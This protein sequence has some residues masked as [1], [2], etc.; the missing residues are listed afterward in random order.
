M[1][2]VLAQ[3]LMASVLVLLAVSLATF[4]LLDLSPGDAAQALVGESASADQIEVLRRELGLDLSMLERYRRF[5]TAAVLRGDLGNSLT[6]G[7]PIAP[8]LAERFR[9]TLVLALAA[10][11]LALAIG[12]P[13]AVVA[14]ARP[15]GIGDSLGMVGA[16]LGLSM[17]TFWLAL[18][19]MLT[20][21]LRLKWLPVKGAGSPAHLILPAVSLALPLA[22]VIARLLRSSLLEVRQ[23]DHVRTAR[24]KGLTRGRLWQDHLLRNSIVPTVTVV[25]LHLGH[26]L[27]GTFVVETIFA[28]P[29]LGSLIVRAVFER[30]YPT[31]TA[32]ALLIAVVYQ[33]LNLAVDL[34]QAWLDP[35]TRQRAAAG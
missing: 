35:R 29:G 32:A 30:D 22:A 5:V 23:A 31:V 27:G 8:L 33:F 34:L 2:R 26:L 15:G 7:R 13:V 24:A 11:G 19:M 1:A 9:H 4:A 17:P 16:L 14:S 18:M 3:R 28:W 25:A 6:S 21:S 10:T 12:G 20:F